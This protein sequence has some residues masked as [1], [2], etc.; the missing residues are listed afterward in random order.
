MQADMDELV[1]MRLDGK[2]AELLIRVNPELYQP[3]VVYENG[4]PVL[5]VILKRLYTVRSELLFSSGGGCRISLSNGDSSRTHMILV[6]PTRTLMGNSA[7]S[8]GMWMI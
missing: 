5:N 3:Y 8:N 1:H 7:P 6:W 4:K 2:M